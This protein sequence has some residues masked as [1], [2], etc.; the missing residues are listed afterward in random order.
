MAQPESLLKLPEFWRFY[1]PREG[2]GPVAFAGADPHQFDNAE[3][4][5]LKIRMP[6][7][8][9][10]A[11]VVDINFDWML[12]LSFA[13]DRGEHQLGWWDEARWHPFALRWSELE[14]M[15]AFWESNPDECPAT[16]T[17]RLLLLTRF[18]G[19]PTDAEPEIDAAR[20]RIRNAYRNQGLFHE[21]ELDA[22]VK[23]T[24]VLP[25][26]DDYRWSKHESLGWTFGGEYPC[27]SLRNPEHA[28]S[29]EG[30]F[31]FKEFNQMMTSVSSR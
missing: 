21:T 14:Q 25:T 11:I 17:E 10:T 6:C 31:P 24:V 19:I 20:T 27:Y 26:E 12:T 4:R 28:G 9:S 3:N 15:I 5:S 30:D 18:V 2:I 1:H 7:P 16:P 29:S 22:M 23:S 13:S 8:L